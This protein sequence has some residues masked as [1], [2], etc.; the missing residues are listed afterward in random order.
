MTTEGIGEDVRQFIFEYIDSVE[1]LEVLLYLR[2]HPDDSLS[3]Q[4]VSQEMRSTPDSV[5][6]RMST[7]EAQGFASGDRDA[8]FRYKADTDADR[9]IGRVEECYRLRPH[10]VMELIF[11][12]MKKARGFAEAFVVKRRKSEDSNG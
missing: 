10:K 4:R 9:V 1:Q 2:H 12:P 7:L 3:P 5:A 6:G 8:G 11:S